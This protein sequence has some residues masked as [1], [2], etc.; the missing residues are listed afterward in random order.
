MTE[1]PSGA[2][3][4]AVIVG[5]G[6]IGL[7]IAYELLRRDRSVLLIERDRPGTGTSRVAGGMLAP[8]CEA[9]DQPPVMTDLC[10]DAARRYPE[11]VAELERVSGTA[12]GYRKEGTLWVAL[13]RDDIGE[14]ARLESILA[15]RDLPFEPLDAKR[16]AVIEPRLSSRVLD[17]LHVADDR[18]VDPRALLHA[19]QRAVQRLGGRFLCP[20]TVHEI[21]VENGRVTGIWT[22]SPHDHDGGDEILAASNVVVCAG[23]WTTA[24]I[25]MPEPVAPVRPVKGQL[26]RL[27]GEALDAKRQ[28]ISLVGVD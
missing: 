1:N 25:R 26:V 5:A 3:F 27:R 10:L 16:I 18:Q 7:S 17:G 22:G 4:D 23:A 24:A 20:S 9:E 19:L 12:T 21:V 6:V 15:S 28:P 11:F 2:A 14:L 8:I 13:H